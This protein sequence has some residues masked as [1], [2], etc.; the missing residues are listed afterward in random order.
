MRAN[1]IEIETRRN[2][3]WK[4]R[5]MQF[6][7]SRIAEE[8]GV[9]TA[10]IERDMTHITNELIQDISKVEEISAEAL[11]LTKSDIAEATK[12][13]ETTSNPQIKLQAIDRRNRSIKQ[14]LLIC[15]ISERNSLTIT[16]NNTS[17]SNRELRIHILG[18]PENEHKDAGKLV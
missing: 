14:L 1:K 5:T 7:Q 2:N 6:S 15:G 8:L 12:I 3:V 17:I 18:D 9:S 10:T 16:Q 4:L 11:E 13:I